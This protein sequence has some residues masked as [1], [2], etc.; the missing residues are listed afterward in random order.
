MSDKTALVI[1]AH[2]A[3]FVW[4][5]GGRSGGRNAK[6]AEGFQSM[7]PRTVDEL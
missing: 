5:A 7:F 1:S 3:D 2:A 6:C 4:R